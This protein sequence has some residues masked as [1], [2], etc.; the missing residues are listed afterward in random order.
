MNDNTV[1]PT[2]EEP[3]KKKKLKK[4]KPP[5]TKSQIALRIS[6][7][8][9]GVLILILLTAGIAVYALFSHYYNQMNIVNPFDTDSPYY[10]K[11]EIIWDIPDETDDPND[12]YNP[13]VTS[14]PG[15]NPSTGDTPTT[16]APPV[17]DTPITIEDPP[18]EDI[19]YV[20]QFSDKV[21]NILLIGTDG[22]TASERGR[23]DSM[24]LLSINEE[25]G[26]IVMTSLMRDIYL[27]IPVVDTYN[28]INAAYAYG[29][30]SLLAQTIEENFKIHI[31]KYVRINFTGFE[32]VVDILDGVDVRL[33][34]EEI[35]FVGLEG[36]A[37]PGLVHLDGAAA[38]KFCR[39]R[40]LPRNGLSGDF[41][42]TARQ[43]ELLTLVSDKL[44]TKSLTEINNLLNKFLPEVTTNL[45]KDE[46]LSMLTKIT[47]YFSY[48]I[49]SYSL[50]ISG[51]W[52]YA[53]IRGMSVLSVDFKKNY[54]ALEKM[55]KGSYES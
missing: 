24:I 35:N 10:S 5:V 9:L 37:S 7:I 46:L 36:K 41:A 34:A 11:E 23:S 55:I 8:V 14:Q 45:T 15:D 26:Q 2:P 17:T 40:Y 25:T 20:M 43:R 32:K 12:I 4:K 28:R 51:S 21:K 1:N 33:S 54:E 44:R 31:D 18:T 29:G 48:D 53:T 6:L 39:C 38:L 42:R 16:E 3:T 49:K 27:H 13:P 47:T 50:P 30:V 52:K 22:R 19:G